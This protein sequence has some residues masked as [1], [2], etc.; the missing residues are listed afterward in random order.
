[1]NG[2]ATLHIALQWSG[3]ERDDKVIT[4][5]LTF[6]ATANAIS[7]TGAHPVF[8]DVDKETMGLLPAAVEAWLNEN[9]ELRPFSPS[10]LLPL[11]HSSTLPLS[12]SAF[13]QTHQPPNS[14]LR[15]HAHLRPPG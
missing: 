4:Q 14:R 3:V 15:P 6:I 11:F 2:T 1:M 13:Q 10:P 7:Y 5:S 8:L 9:V 12:S